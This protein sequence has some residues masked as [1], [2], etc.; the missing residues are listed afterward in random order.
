M[1]SGHRT[2]GGRQIGQSPELLQG[3]AKQVPSLAH[4]PN[5]I[6]H[7]EQ[8]YPH[9]SKHDWNR[10]DWTSQIYIAFEA[11][12][13]DSSLELKNV[14]RLSFY[15]HGQGIANVTR[16]V[17]KSWAPSLF[18]SKLH[19]KCICSQKFHPTGIDVYTRSH[20]LASTKC[21]VVYCKAPATE[22]L[23]RFCNAHTTGSPH[24]H[25]PRPGQK[26]Q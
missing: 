24:V 6:T 22:P 23:V 13:T 11:E 18:N 1:L 19:K 26:Y 15:A 4:N 14:E 16:Y 17:Y 7:V 9:N 25:S 21:E 8:N 10:P 20:H 12:Q 2:T 5:T 3:S